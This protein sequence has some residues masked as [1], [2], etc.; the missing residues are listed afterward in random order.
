MTSHLRKRHFLI[1]RLINDFMENFFN[2]QYLKLNTLMTSE[3]IMGGLND[4]SQD[5]QHDL[6]AKSTAD[7]LISSVVGFCHFL[8]GLTISFYNLDLL[9]FSVVLREGDPAITVN[10][11]WIDKETVFNFLMMQ[12][13]HGEHS[14]KLLILV[15]ERYFI[16]SLVFRRNLELLKRKGTLEDIGLTQATFPFEHSFIICDHKLPG[17]SIILFSE[18]ALENK[19]SMIE[20]A[21]TKSIF[22]NKNNDYFAL[23]F[24]H[25]VDNQFIEDRKKRIIEEN[26]VTKLQNKKMIRDAT[27]TKRK[28]S[29]SLIELT[30]EKT[31][32]PALEGERDIM[33]KDCYA[34]K[35]ELKTC[36][37]LSSIMALKKACLT[38]SPM[39]KFSQFIS[40]LEQLTEEFESIS[41]SNVKALDLN[42]LLSLTINMIIKAGIGSFSTDIRLIQTFLRV[43]DDSPIKNV[44]D[45]LRAAVFTINRIGEE[46]RLSNFN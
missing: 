36:P 29:A 9:Q 38:E 37:F 4:L 32:N 1:R 15:R 30:E 21:G 43:P 3:S 45:L 42:I 26:Q 16:E 34:K 44:M 28:G 10:P 12:I 46:K 33:S 25:S 24:R 2:L 7:L 20:P 31:Q 14:T 11:T 6:E 23:N 41:K 18:S 39:T 22:F 5:Y 35:D 8:T 27:T 17:E 40:F 13:F 19:S